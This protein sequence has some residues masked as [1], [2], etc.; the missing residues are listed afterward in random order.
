MNYVTHELMS[1]KQLKARPF[2]SR[3]WCQLKNIQKSYLTIVYD[4]CLQKNFHNTLKYAFPKLCELWPHPWQQEKISRN[5]YGCGGSISITCTGVCIRIHM[6][7]SNCVA[8]EE[9]N[10]RHLQ[11]TKAECEGK[12]SCFLQPSEELYGKVDSCQ[13]KDNLSTLW[14]TYCDG[15]T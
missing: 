9:V 12:E 1:C 5:I 3:L 8:K 7:L 15:G 14:L 6:A 2:F 13:N 11:L 4:Y 10:P